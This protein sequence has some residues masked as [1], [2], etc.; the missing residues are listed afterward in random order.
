[1]SNKVLGDMPHVSESR[2]VSAQHKGPDIS[3]LFDKVCDDWDASSDQ[4]CYYVKSDILKREW[5]PPDV[6]FDDDWTVKHQLVMPKAYRT[7][8]LHM[9]HEMLV[10]GHLDVKKAYHKILNHFFWPGLK[11]VVI[12]FC[13]SRHTCQVVGKPSQTIPKALFK[14]LAVFHESWLIV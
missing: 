4:V 6:S 13:K 8:I 14:R 2:S 1:M 10:A 9:A 11:T 7:E 12:Q 5:R 3:S